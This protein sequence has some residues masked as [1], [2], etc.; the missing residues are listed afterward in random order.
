MSS[1][2]YLLA[3]SVKYFFQPIYTD[4]TFHILKRV[5]LKSSPQNLLIQIKLNRTD[6]L[7][8]IH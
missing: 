2:T 3:F 7:I 6:D 1:S 4:F 8:M 5:T